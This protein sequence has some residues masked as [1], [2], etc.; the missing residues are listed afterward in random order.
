MLDHVLVLFNSTLVPELLIFVGVSIW[1]ELQ[2]GTEFA[3]NSKGKI[4]DDKLSLD[5]G[6]KF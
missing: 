6:A 5:L 1:R 4:V 2:L 3:R